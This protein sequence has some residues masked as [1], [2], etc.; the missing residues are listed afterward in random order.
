MKTFSAKPSDIDKKWISPIKENEMV[1]TIGDSL[2]Y[3]TLK[4]MTYDVKRATQV[5]NRLFILANI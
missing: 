5:S 4:D 2:F 3:D 1:Y